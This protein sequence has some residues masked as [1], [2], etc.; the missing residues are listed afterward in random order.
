MIDN[1]DCKNI[2]H[3]WYNLLLNDIYIH[4]KIC[5]YSFWIHSMRPYNLHE[6]GEYVFFTEINIFKMTQFGGYIQELL[7]YVIRNFHEAFQLL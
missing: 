4:K 5:W 3:L 1:I 2:N 6:I 7:R